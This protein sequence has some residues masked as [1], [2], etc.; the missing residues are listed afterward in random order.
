M[1]LIIKHQEQYS[2]L[3]LL[4]RTFFGWL[5]IALPHGFILF[6]LNIWAGIL[7]FLAFWA[8][9]FAG[10]YPK[11]FYSFQ[12]SLQRWYIRL[13]AR[14]YNLSDGYPAFG[15]KGTDEHTEF[16]MPYPEKLS[17]GLL[18]LRLLFGWLYVGIPHGFI[19]FFRGIAT[20]FIIF[21]AWFIVLFA[22][23]YPSG[24]HSFVTGTIRW[25]TR[26]G[27]YMMFLT[28]QYPPFTGKELE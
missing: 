3:E 5:Y 20:G 21:I 17:R 14:L 19:L 16:D 22:G 28:D 7:T 24:M 26:V 1:K 8:V 6:F 13:R 12:V 18:I 23:K 15:I 9:L 4:L 27:V 2:R 11:S 10:K 25:F